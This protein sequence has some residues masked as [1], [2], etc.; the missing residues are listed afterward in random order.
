MNIMYLPFDNILDEQRHGSVEEDL[1]L[2]LEVEEQ[3]SVE[4]GVLERLHDGLA[5]VPLLLEHLL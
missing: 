2:L 4:P 3:F 5:Q 1:I